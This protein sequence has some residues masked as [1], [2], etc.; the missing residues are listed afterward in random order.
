MIT[1]EE[2][3][4][5][6]NRQRIIENNF[7]DLETIY[8][9]SYGRDKYWEFLEKNNLHPMYFKYVFGSECIINIKNKIMLKI[10]D[11]TDRPDC[12]KV[13]NIAMMNEFETILF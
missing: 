7:P 9:Y 8:V 11:W 13:C 1:K 12:N 10:D 5:L 4:F 2:I 6:Y 3:F